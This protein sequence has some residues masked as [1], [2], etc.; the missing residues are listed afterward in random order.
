MLGA[1]LTVEGC[2][3]LTANN[4]VLDV[5]GLPPSRVGMFLYGFAQQQVPFGNGWGCITGGI[6]RVLPALLSSPTGTVNHPI[7]LTQFPFT[8]SAHPI[9]PSSAWNFQFWYRDPNG[10]PTTFNLSDALHIAFAP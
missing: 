7:D 9:L 6:Q 3:G 4:L 5:S 1:S 10:S 8:G 2:P